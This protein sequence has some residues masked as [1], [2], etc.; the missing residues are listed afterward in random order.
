MSGYSRHEIPAANLAL[1]DNAVYVYPYSDLPDNIKIQFMDGTIQ[2]PFTD[3]PYDWS[4]C[5]STGPFTIAP[6][7]SAVAAFAIIGGDNL[8][9]LKVNADTAY[10]RYWKWPGVKEVGSRALVS[11]VKLYPVISHNRPYTIQ[12][13]FNNETSVHLWVYDVAG[14]LITEKNYE[15]LTGSGEIPLEFTPFSQG[16][17]FVHLEAG[18]RVITEKLIWLK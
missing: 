2:N 16:I 14:R 18:N 3:R 17:Y 12:Y 5:N 15:G 10:D 9:D 1:I 11:G 8:N 7:D 4:T 6:G 13:S